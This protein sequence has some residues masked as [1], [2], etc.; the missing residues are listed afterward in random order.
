MFLTIPFFIINFGEKNYG[1][2]AVLSS[3]TNLNIIVNVGLK[4]ALVKF[5]AEQVNK[6]ESNYDIIT[7]IIITSI[8]ILIIVTISILFSDYFIYNVLKVTIQSDNILLIYYSFIFSLVLLFYGQNLRAIL[9]GK[10]FVFLSNISLLVYNIVFWG[11]L[12]LVSLFTNRFIFIIIPVIS[13]VLIWFVLLLLFVKN[14]WGK[15]TIIG[16]K[17]NYKFHFKKNLS[18]SSKSLIGGILLLLFEPTSKVF[19][20]FLLGP[21]V[22]GTYDIVLRVKNQLWKL[23]SR[24]LMPLFPLIASKQQN[25]QKENII[26]RIQKN[27]L[28]VV[29]ITIFIIIITSKAFLTLWLPHTVDYLIIGFNIVILTYLINVISQPF[30]YYLM[31]ENKLNEVITLNSINF[32]SNLIILFFIYG[33]IGNLSIFIS[34]SIAILLSFFVSNIYQKKIFGFSISKSINENIYTYASFISV[35]ISIVFFYINFESEN[36]SLLILIVS[37]VL[38]VNLLFLRKTSLLDHNYLINS[39]PVPIFKK[40][41][42]IIM[43]IK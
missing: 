27:I 25:Q 2:F 9:D 33:K 3:I 43:D 20:S 42:S 22:I 26:I 30:Y 4:S 14:K 17:E 36:Y 1:I 35:N 10:Q 39:I 24:A 23:F 41:Y 19:G 28:P 34:N 31:S 32:I 15:I 16:Y 5:I 6:E 40:I 8:M 7:N 11:G 37:L 29:I 18:F 38:L 21:E 12:L 13:S